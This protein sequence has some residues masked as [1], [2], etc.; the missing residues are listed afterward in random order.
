[1]VLLAALVILDVGS[2]L[3]FEADLTHP[4]NPIELKVMTYNVFFKNKHPNSTVET[5]RKA[6]P[7]VLLIQELTPK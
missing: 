6:D 4:E 7:D 5:I 2:Q 1:M 3:L